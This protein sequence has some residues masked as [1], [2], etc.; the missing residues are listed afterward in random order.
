MEATNG[1]GEEN[2]IKLYI[3][4]RSASTHK[5]LLQVSTYIQKYTQDQSHYIQEHILILNLI[6]IQIIAAIF[7]FFC[8]SIENAWAGMLSNPISPSREK[9]KVKI[10]CLA[11]WHKFIYNFKIYKTS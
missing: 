1:N 10:D 7:P 2:K 11:S 3:L 6:T 4:T 5:D 8:F 9:M